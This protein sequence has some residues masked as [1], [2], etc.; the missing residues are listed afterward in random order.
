MSAEITEPS[1][2]SAELTNVA[3]EVN[4]AAPVKIV[5]SSDERERDGIAISIN[6]ITS[7]VKNKLSLH[8]NDV[9]TSSQYTDGVAS[10]KVL[11]TSID[12][13][14]KLLERSN[15]ALKDEKAQLMKRLEEIQ[16]A[17]S[18]TS[19]KDPRPTPVVS[20]ADETE[21]EEK[22]QAK[23][24]MSSRRLD[25]PSRRR[26]NSPIDSFSVG[27]DDMRDHHRSKSRSGRLDSQH[28]RRNRGPDQYDDGF[29]NRDYISGKKENPRGE[30]DGDRG[31]KPYRRGSR[32]PPA[33]ANPL[34]R[35]VVF[36]D[37]EDFT[38]FVKHDV[39]YGLLATFG[40]PFENVVIGGGVEISPDRYVGKPNI[41]EPLYLEGIC[42]CTT[43]ALVLHSGKP[44]R[45]AT[46]DFVSIL[47]KFLNNYNGNYFHSKSRPRA[48]FD[49]HVIRCVIY[50]IVQLKGMRRS[51]M[52]LTIGSFAEATEP[53]NL[54][55]ATS[56]IY[57][58][59]GDV[60]PMGVARGL[61][62]ALAT[63]FVSS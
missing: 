26:G 43:S 14:D 46:V 52:T 31:S 35:R 58:R 11:R 27:G 33:S 32:V 56:D 2:L 63:H 57:N 25:N 49:A 55:S 18:T 23:R 8:E 16:R 30:R 13:I 53:S 50:A 61:F 41:C 12:A 59:K 44:L 42:D 39:K 38:L 6:E 4:E 54:L 51:Q 34:T 48:D 20:W 15:T 47:H 21:M 28:G 10:L 40:S 36:D 17:M 60:D 29:D 19:V 3:S 37:Y 22:Y 7:F 24:E 62:V 45:I 1:I 9:L 5:V